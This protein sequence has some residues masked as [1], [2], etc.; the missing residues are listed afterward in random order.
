MSELF[1]KIFNLSITASYIILAVL[2]L[3]PVLRRAPRWIYCALWSIVALRL[4]MPFSIES[5]LS[6]IPSDKTVPTGIGYAETPAI[7]SGIPVIDSVV[8]P[9]MAES[10]SPKTYANSINPMQIVLFLAANVWILGI[11]AILIYGA[12]SYCKLHLKVRPSLRVRDNILYCDQIDTPFILGVFRPRIYIPSDMDEAQTEYVIR[13]EKAHLRRHDHLWKP[14]GFIL[15]AVY[16]FNPLVWIAYILLCR[17]IETA[18]DEKVIKDMGAEDKCGYSEALLSCSIHRMTVMACPLAFG[19]VGVKNRIAS[20]LHYKKPAFW[21]IIIAVLIT[22]FTAVCFLTSP[23]DTMQKITHEK[24]YTI[25]GQKQT[26]IT[27]AI[28]KAVLPNDVLS[29]NGTNFEKNEIIAYRDDTTTIYLRRIQYAN[30]GN[31]NLYFVFD[32]DYTLPRNSGSFLYPYQMNGDGTASGGFYI[33]DHALRDEATVLEDAIFVR[34]QGS[35]TQIAI[36]VS[37]D[38]FCT[39][40]GVMHL[41]TELN[42]LTY[43]RDGAKS[44][45]IKSDAASPYNKDYIEALKKKYPQYFGLDASRGLRVYFSQFAAN[46]YD[47]YLFSAKDSEPD[48]QDLWEATSAEIDE[49]RVILSTYDVDPAMISVTHF[50]HPLSSYIGVGT[51]ISEHTSYVRAKLRLDGN[52]GGAIFKEPPKLLIS[53]GE[54]AFRALLNGYTW[55]YDM[56]NGLSNTS[57]ADT[58][59]PLSYTHVYYVKGY[60][61]SDL[62]ALHFESEPDEVIVDIYDINSEKLIKSAVVTNGLI[63]LLDGDYLYDIKAVWNSRKEYSGTV[64]YSFRTPKK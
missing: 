24:G 5:V 50:Q 9:I 4:V 43:L 11:I 59:H 29:E 22:A 19:E 28:D 60:E 34:G 45:S 63:D 17:D 21:V 58:M 37:T 55:T 23:V 25:V 30:E 2:L 51:E 3:R 41:N 31:H 47:L 42:R 46:S 6:L 52:G 16:W 32:F 14:I 62:A 39:A 26:E 33:S 10:L 56:G 1:I 53:S 64:H 27:L 36:Y 13:H 38:A 12:V 54:H 18:C 57:T 35:G 20:V 61:P 49:M 8:N 7:D 44:P 15:L 40:Q 48:Y